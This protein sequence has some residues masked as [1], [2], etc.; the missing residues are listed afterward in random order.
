[1]KPV[2]DWLDVGKE[3]GRG[4]FGVVYRAVERASKKPVALKLLAPQPELEERGVRELFEQGAR[5]ALSNNMP[6]F[7][8]ILAVEED[9]DCGPYVVMERLDGETLRES[10]RRRSISPVEALQI[11]FEIAMIL[12][13]AHKRGLAHLDLRPANI[14]LTSLGIRILNLGLATL[15]AEHRTKCLETLS[16]MA[17]F[18][19]SAGYVAPELVH[20]GD[21]MSSRS[22]KVDVYAWGLMLYESL[23]GEP[24]I[25]AT[26]TFEMLAEHIQPAPFPIPQAWVRTPMGPLL[27]Q[28]MA[29]APEARLFSAV[30]IEARMCGILGNQGWIEGLATSKSFASIPS[31]R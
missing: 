26:S 17:S 22:P 29:K 7:V 30:E 4:G 2:H 27:S 5:K 18:T 9:P 21:T 14:M 19:G 15:V 23:V 8:Q 28:T 11:H 12:A 1:M 25:K 6:G 3:L 31:P 24:A 16:S 20:G 13:R 10:L